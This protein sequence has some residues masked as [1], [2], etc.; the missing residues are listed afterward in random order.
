[1][2][3]LASKP[4]STGAIHQMNF[5]ANVRM[6]APH[7]SPM[8]DVPLHARERLR[9]ELMPRSSRACASHFTTMPSSVWMTKL[10]WKIIIAGASS[11]L[12]TCS[13]SEAL[14]DA[15]RARRTT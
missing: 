5:G 15:A 6:I 1:M 4:S 7:T 8:R 3:T 10:E 13:A 12:K 11:M 14:Q 9:P 2:G